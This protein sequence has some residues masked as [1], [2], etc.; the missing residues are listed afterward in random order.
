MTGGPALVLT[1]VTRVLY[2]E[3]CLTR[4]TARWLLVRHMRQLLGLP[5]MTRV[6]P[7]VIRG[8]IRGRGTALHVMTP[9]SSTEMA[10]MTRVPARETRAPSTVCHGQTIGSQK[11]LVVP[12][13]TSR[14]GRDSVMMDVTGWQG[15]SEQRE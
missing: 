13:M 8:M 14:W 15:E 5:L 7:M 12:P 9:V 4:V 2:N 11:A 1:I 3:G 10:F 6:A